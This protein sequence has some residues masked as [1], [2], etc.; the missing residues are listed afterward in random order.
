MFIGIYSSCCPP[1]PCIEKNKTLLRM[2]ETGV[3]ITVLVIGIL[4]DLHA[5][6]GSQICGY[7]VTIVGGVWAVGNVII[8]AISTSRQTSTATKKK[9]PTAA[10]NKPRLNKRHPEKIRSRNN[11]P[12][13]TQVDSPKELEEEGNGGRSNR[14]ASIQRKTSSEES[15]EEDEITS[16][17]AKK[18]V[19]D[20]FNLTLSNC[21]KSVDLT[22]SYWLEKNPSCSAHGALLQ[23]KVHADFDNLRGDCKTI[24]VCYDML[25]GFE[26]AMGV[27]FD[28]PS[29]FPV[30]KMCPND[31]DYDFSMALHVLTHSRLGDYF[32][33]RPIQKPMVSQFTTQSEYEEK[34]K[35]WD[36]RVQLQAKVKS[37]VKEM[38]KGEIPTSEDHKALDELKESLEKLA[39]QLP[40]ETS[41]WL[42]NQFGIDF[43]ECDEDQLNRGILQEAGNKQLWPWNI[44][45]ATCSYHEC[46]VIVRQDGTRVILR[47]KMTAISDIPCEKKELV[48]YQ[49]RDEI[50][51]PISTITIHL[52]AFL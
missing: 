4:I 48:K 17:R 25:L 38:R 6:P 40:E 29:P 30:V 31:G 10:E 19:G 26:Y 49:F 23:E 33:N 3:S 45:I 14:T 13:T 1:Q 34:K 5:M 32:L 44:L 35:K 2:A 21:K 7:I 20:N 43:K 51:F 12:P 11:S 47:D 9:M 27:K 46:T 8:I 39:G 37:L 22:I 16:E 42:L 24:Q 41:R 50:Y 36:I 18:I 15:D 28:S 52:A